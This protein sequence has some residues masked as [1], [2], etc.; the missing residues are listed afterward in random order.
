MAQTTYMNVFVH[1]LFGWGESNPIYAKFP[2]WGMASGNVLKDLRSRGYLCCAPDFGPVSSSWDRACELYSQLVGGR[3]DYGAA[4]AAEHG[5]ERFGR[6][7][8]ALYPQWSAEKKINLIAHSFGGATCRMLL[9][10][11]SSGSEAE[12]TACDDPSPLFQGGKG[13]WVH[14]I[15]CLASPHN[16]STLGLAAEDPVTA[17]TEMNTMLAKNMIAQ[18][19]AHTY[20]VMLDQFGAAYDTAQGFVENMKRLVDI[21]IEHKDGAFFELHV[22]GALALNRKISMQPNVYY[23]SEPGCRTAPRG[24]GATQ[25]PQRTMPPIFRKTAALMGGFCDA[26]TPGGVKIDRTWCPNDGMVNT[27]S[28]L[29]PMGDPHREI[30]EGE[31]AFVPGVW[32]VLPVRNLDHLEMVGGFGHPLRTRKHFHALMERIDQTME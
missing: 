14:S 13:E 20:D 29:C 25:R 3:V 12:C 22:D 2:Q 30:R 18:N 21:T 23:F 26:K 15:T 10:L 1:G 11:L 24:S 17:V 4:H 9:E 27:V 28:A 5:H 32:N 8:A 16:G 7:Y 19:P 31:T 6:T